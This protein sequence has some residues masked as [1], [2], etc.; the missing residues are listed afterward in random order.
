[1]P[2][3]LRPLLLLTAAALLLHTGSGCGSG[4]EPPKTIKVVGKVLYKDR[5][6]AVGAIM[7]RPVGDASLLA[8]ARTEPDGSFALATVFD[9]RRLDGAIPGEHTVTF[10]PHSRDQSVGPVALDKKY[11]VKDEAGH[12]FTIVVDTLPPPP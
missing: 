12:E 4:K 10:V 9:N 6:P 1:M 3:F 2:S 11:T 8:S 7:F 5:T